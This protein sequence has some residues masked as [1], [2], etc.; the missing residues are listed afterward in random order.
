MK[1][2]LE[3]QEDPTK[4]HNTK[5]EAPGVATLHDLNPMADPYQDQSVRCIVLQQR[6]LPLTEKDA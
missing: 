2:L 5:V 4:P 1:T 6:T 3:V